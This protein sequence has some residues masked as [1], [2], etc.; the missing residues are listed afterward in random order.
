MFG[1][2]AYIQV[3]TDN[4]I[5]AYKTGMSLLPRGETFAKCEIFRSCL[6]GI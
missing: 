4:I 5:Y 3:S 2:L 1:L 6:I